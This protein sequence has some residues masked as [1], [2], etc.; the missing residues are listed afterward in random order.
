LP[1]GVAVKIVDG[2]GHMPHLEKAAEINALLKTA[3]A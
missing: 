1:A 3:L 2:A